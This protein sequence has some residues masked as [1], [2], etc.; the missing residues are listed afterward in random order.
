MTWQS[1]SRLSQDFFNF[2]DKPDWDLSTTREGVDI[3]KLFVRCYR[4]LRDSFYF[5]MTEKLAMFFKCVVIA[6]AEVE[7]KTIECI[8]KTHIADAHE[9]T[10]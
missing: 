2:K 10:P 8:A 7:S 6:I 4:N 1:G 3:C 5:K 9:N